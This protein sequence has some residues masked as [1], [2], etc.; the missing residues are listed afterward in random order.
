MHTS[1][2]WGTGM[3]FQRSG[4]LTV[5]FAVVFVSP[6]WA[7]DADGDGVE[8]VQ[9]LCC[10]TPEGV[11]VDPFGRP[12]GDLDHDCDVDLRDIAMMLRALHAPGRPD[13]P[14]DNTCQFSEHCSDG[15]F[16][17]KPTGECDAMGECQERPLGCLDYYDPVCGCDGKTHSNSCYAQRDR[18]N[19]AYKGPCS[20]CLLPPDTGPCDGI[21]PRYFF[22]ARTERCEEFA[23]GCCGGNSNNFLTLRECEASCP[24]A[25]PCSLRPDGGI[26]LAVIPRYYFDV[27]TGT[28]QLFIYGGCGGNANNFE[29]QVECEQRC[30]GVDPCSLPPE[31]GPCR[32][33]IQRYFFD[34]ATGTCQLF[35]YGG[36]GGNANNFES[37]EACLSVCDP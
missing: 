20:P 4:L 35:I 8:D 23:Y 21:C 1:T 36:C 17:H 18:T 16:C 28:C 7:G 11:P 33:V 14:C 32:A 3:D 26:C 31:T 2:S 24:P 13:G 25:S 15:E 19:V 5:L 12:I 10:H 9:D 34:S 30:A 22:D 6:A 37:L 29:T 27:H